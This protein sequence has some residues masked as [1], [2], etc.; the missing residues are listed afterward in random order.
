[1]QDKPSDE[2]IYQPSPPL[3]EPPPPIVEPD[4][5]LGR[6]AVGLAVVILLVGIILFVYLGGL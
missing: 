3:I 5:T 1:M 2:V 4:Q 6:L